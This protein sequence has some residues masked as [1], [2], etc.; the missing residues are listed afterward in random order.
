MGRG[1]PADG[2]HGLRS[3]ASASNQAAHHKWPRTHQPRT[4]AAHP[5]ASIFPNTAALLRLVSTLLAECDEEWLTGKIY[6][7][8][9]TSAA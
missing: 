3:A 5:V 1:E 4:Q 2:L 8:L 7:S 9:E 6:L